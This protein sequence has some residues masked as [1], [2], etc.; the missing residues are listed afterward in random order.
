MKKVS[1]GGGPRQ[2]TWRK[3]SARRHSLH[4]PVGPHTLIPPPICEPRWCKPEQAPRGHKGQ[5]I[6][7]QVR[8]ERSPTPNQNTD[9]ERYRPYK[10]RKEKQEGH[11]IGGS[12]SM[13]LEPR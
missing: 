3:P 5:S 12:I 6:Y 11:V 4:C 2:T 8:G 10:N 1:D 7:S 9:K 13:G